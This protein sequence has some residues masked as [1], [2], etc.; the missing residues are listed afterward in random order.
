MGGRRNPRQSGW[1][2]TR[3]GPEFGGVVEVQKLDKCKY[4]YNYNYSYKSVEDCI[5]WELEG[6]T[7]ALFVNSDIVCHLID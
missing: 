7:V 6:E 4:N 2:E 1:K 5:A 3:G